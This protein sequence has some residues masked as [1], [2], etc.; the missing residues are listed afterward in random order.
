MPVFADLDNDGDYD[1]LMGE[2]FGTSYGYENTGSVTSPVWTAKTAWNT[3][4]VGDYAKP[5]FADLDNDGDYDSLI[6]E[7]AGVS[8]AYENTG[9]GGA[10]G[11]TLLGLAVNGSEKLRVTGAGAINTQG[12]IASQSYGSFTYNGDLAA[13]TVRQNGGGNILDLKDGADTIFTVLNGGNVGIG[14]ASPDT[15]LKVIGSLCVKST[16]AACAGTTAGTIYATNTTVQGADYAE[17]FAT[18]DTDLKPGEAVC[19]DAQKDNA[20]K[21]C[22]RSGDSDIMG[23]V[24]GHPSIV[25]NSAD[26]REKDPHYKVIG[27]LGQIAANVSGENGPIQIGDSLTSANTPGYLRKAD[28]GESTVGVALQKFDRQQGSIQMLISRR[29][30]SL[31]VEKVEEAV[32]QRIAEMK[33]EDQVNSMVANATAELEKNTQAQLISIDGRVIT[34]ETIMNGYE[35]RLK[36]QED[37]TATFQSQMDELK[38]LANEELNLA[39]IGANKTDIDYL[40]LVSGP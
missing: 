36:T 34:L 10:I 30:K 5:A 23:I 20:V 37:L 26:G 29:N 27:M 39:Q 9:S 31:T 35:A 22:A 33:V 13:L 32:T 18:R 14:T 15:T 28:A 11:N 38:K 40:K 21:R 24:S 7:S 19:V 8:Y 1:L 4:D 25:G 3:P 17:Y 2:R 12:Y 16:D 6:G